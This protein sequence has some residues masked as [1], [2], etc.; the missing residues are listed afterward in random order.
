MGNL[1]H[2]KCGKYCFYP[3]VDLPSNSVKLV[4]RTDNHNRQNIHELGKYNEL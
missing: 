3:L 4:A 1:P 2:F